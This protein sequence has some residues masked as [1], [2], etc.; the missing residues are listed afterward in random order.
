MRLLLV[1]A[2]PYP[3]PQGSQVYFQE[4]AI[5]LRAAGAHVELLTYASGTPPRAANP[6]DWRALDGFRHHR[7]PRWSAPRTLRSG[8]NLAKP[9]ADLALAATL[10]RVLASAEAAGGF[11]AILAHHAEAAA[12]SA[13]ALSL[14]GSFGSSFGGRTRPRPALVYCVHT[15]LGRE[16][17]AYFGP[18]ARP[19]TRGRK[20]ALDRFGRFVDHRLARWADGWI[21]LT[22]S[23]AHAMRRSSTAPGASIPPPIPASLELDDAFDPAVVARRHG[24]VPGRFD[25]YSGNLD[26]YQELERLVE[27]QR[28]RAQTAHSTPEASEANGAT[29]PAGTP[30]P[31]V[32]ASHDAAVLGSERLRERGL[33]VRHVADPREMRA[34]LSAARASLVMR[35]AEGGYPIKLVNS[36]AAG[37][38]PVAFLEREWGLTDGENAII[39]RGDDP[40]V[41]FA[42]ALDRLDRE[43]ALAPR[44]GCGARA[45]YEKNHLPGRVAEQ[46]LALLERILRTATG[47]AGSEPPKPG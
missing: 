13:L 20:R 5:A 32:V 1:G 45:L 42:E 8:P 9:V 16:L 15:L 40:T 35:R 19:L 30:L 47:G 39:A 22:P 23:A 29:Q 24:L 28:R 27:V 6:P 43:P 26:A 11:D 17:S 25:L 34:L 31:I 33:L 18:A 4:Q 3:F 36:L 7:G 44:L 12:A 21:A 46:S 41:A 14:G 38:P 10:R 37:T 2:F